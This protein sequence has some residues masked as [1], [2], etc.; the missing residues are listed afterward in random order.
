[1]VVATGRT[2]ADAQREI[3]RLVT[4]RLRNIVVDV[5]LGKLRSV[6]ADVVGGVKNPGA[7]DISALSTCLSA[8]ITAGGPTETGS[9]RT[10]KHYRGKALVEEVDLYNLMLKGV[11][12][13]GE[14]N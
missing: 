13:G 10:V 1:V 12:G 7:Y 3:S 2:L 14:D 6:R 5:G 4:R 11:S 9:Y 8:L